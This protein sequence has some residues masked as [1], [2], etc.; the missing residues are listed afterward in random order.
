MVFTAL[1]FQI[2]DPELL[3][4]A[5]RILSPSCILLKTIGNSLPY[6]V[7]VGLNGRIWVKGRSTVET[8]ALSNAIC[9]A[10]FMTN[11]HIKVL[12]RQICDALSG[13]WHTHEIGNPKH[14]DQCYNL[15][16]SHGGRLDGAN[17]RYYSSVYWELVRGFTHRFFQHT[18]M[19]D[20]LTWVPTTWT[21]PLCTSCQAVSI[22]IHHA[23]C[24]R[25]LDKK[26]DKS[27]LRLKSI[28]LALWLSKG[29]SLFL[30]FQIWIKHMQ[31]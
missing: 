19:S 6:E 21:V 10:E 17:T 16:T 11:D 5:S 14:L 4:Y 30:E 31:F 20:A 8:I 27:K 15:Y 18:T 24:G 26:Q 2:C 29:Y 22:S 1:I 7:A 12:V 9:S 25:V 28:I 13:F 23:F 3:R